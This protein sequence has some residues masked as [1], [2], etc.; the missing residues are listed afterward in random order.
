M[1]LEDKQWIKVLTLTTT[2]AA[3]GVSLAAWKIYMKRCVQG[4]H[5]DLLYSLAY[6][7]PRRSLPALYDH[8]L[9]AVHTSGSKYPKVYSIGGH[10]TSSDYMEVWVLDPALRGWKEVL[11]AV[12]ADTKQAVFANRRCHAAAGVGS[13]IYVIGGI[14][15][16]TVGD[17]LKFD[18]EK[19]RWSTPC[20]SGDLPQA[21]SGHSATVVGKKV[22]VFGG[23][24]EDSALNDVH[25]LDTENGSWTT[26]IVLGFPPAPRSTHSA[27]LLEDG[28]R[29]LIHGGHSS[30]AESDLWFLE[31]RTA[32]V[33]RHQELLGTEVVAWSKGSVGKSPQPVVICGPSGVGKGTLIARLMKEYPSKFGF[34]VSHTTRKPRQ[35]EQDGVHYHFTQREVMEKDVREGKFL[36]S[37]DVHGNLYGT[38]IAAVEAVADAG[39]RCI[40]DID[41]QGAELVKKSPLDALFIFISPPT[42]QELEARLRGRGTETEEQIRNRLKN[43][44]AEMDRSGDVTLFDHLLVNDKIDDTYEQLKKL[45]GLRTEALENGVYEREELIPEARSGHSSTVF[46]SKVLVYGGLTNAGTPSNDLLALDTSRLTN[47]APATTRG[48]FWSRPEPKFDLWKYL[49][50]S[51]SL[52]P[53]YNH[54]AVPLSLTEILLTGGYDNK[55]AFNHSIVLKLESEY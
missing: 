5:R 46:E 15:N 53:R 12:N 44:K 55:Q 10:G 2:L 43:A 34:S 23:Q 19:E 25:V 6:A 16:T 26:P 36:E 9:S 1:G 33:K 20:F 40:L 52:S 37:A 54:R 18:T 7:G 22:Y 3:A 27:V 47:G 13:D 29:I 32:F 49:S 42:F 17:V 45:L 51:P 24:G 8:T 11:P 21:R 4:G 50:L 41:V 31:I 48:L 35:M 28:E 39:K 30:T 38:S 14:T